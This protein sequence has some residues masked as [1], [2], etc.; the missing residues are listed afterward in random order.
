MNTEELLAGI[1][2]S[3]RRSIAKAIT[4]IEST[5]CQDKEKADELLSLL[6]PHASVSTRIGISG[7]PGV[8]KSTFI[9]NFGQHLL[10]EDSN[11]KIAILAIDPSSPVHGGSI[12]AD[13]TRMAELSHSPRVFIRPTPSSGKL[14]GIAQKTRETILIMEAAGFDTIIVETVGVG[15]SEYLVGQMVDLF[16]VLQMPHTGDELQGFKKGILELSD[17][18][19]IN[20]ADGKLLPFAKIAQR[21]HQQALHYLSHSKAWIAPVLLCSSLNHEG[22]DEISQTMQ[23]FIKEQKAKGHFQSKRSQQALYWFDEEF[24]QLVLEQAL[25]QANQQGLYQDIKTKVELGKLPPSVA[26]R[27]MLQKI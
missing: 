9:E 7:I 14:G 5:R 26:A 22:F 8:G 27:H 12:L 17:L 15:Q 25:K 23:Q 16:M 24:K 13:K 1:L 20:K 10:Q 3:N 21:E 19:V 18:L 11:R 6:S 4:L 2:K